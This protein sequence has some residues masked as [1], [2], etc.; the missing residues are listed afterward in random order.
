MLCSFCLRHHL[1]ML[2]PLLMSTSI[3]FVMSTSY[4]NVKVTR[5]CVWV[6]RL[7]LTVG[8]FRTS[9]TQCLFQCLDIGL[10]TGLKKSHYLFQVLN[11]NDELGHCWHWQRL[12]FEF[13]FS[14]CQCTFVS[15]LSKFV[16]ICFTFS[17]CSLVQAMFLLLFH[18]FI[19]L[20]LE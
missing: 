5:I 8:V 9:M 20:V 11:K 15:L 1:S 6:L 18:L 14:N 16:E 2:T 19:C 7:L 17:T 4:I 12:S 3:D 10:N 13:P